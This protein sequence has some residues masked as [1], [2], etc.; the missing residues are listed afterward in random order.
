MKM[1][2]RS[3]TWNENRFSYLLNRTYFVKNRIYFDNKFRHITILSKVFWTCNPWSC[4][5]IK[6]ASPVVYLQMLFSIIGYAENIK[7]PALNLL[8][9][10]KAYILLLHNNL[11]YSSL[12]I[13]TLLFSC[14]NISWIA[15]YH[16]FFLH[17]FTV[18]EFKL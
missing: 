6:T 14:F 10:L 2:D 8:E 3:H 12:S 1:F 16:K 18:L 17:V 13:H 7:Q 5:K 11:Q 4:W 9:D 15:T